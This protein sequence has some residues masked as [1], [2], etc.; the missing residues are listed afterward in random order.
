MTAALPALVLRRR[1]D[2]RLRTGHPW[3]FSNEVDTARTPLTQFRPGDWVNLST[4]GGRL[5]GTAYVNP[6]TLIAAR[7]VSRQ[8]DRPLDR[9]CIKERVERALSLRDRLYARP[10]Y[11]LVYAESDGLPG[12]VIDR[13]GEVLVAQTGTQGMERLRGDIAAAVNECLE[14]RSLVFRNDA[15]ARTIEGLAQYV[16]TV[17]GD[18]PGSIQIDENGA[19]FEIDP[20]GG[21]KSGW[22]Y[23]HRDNRARL[24]R[25]VRDAR[26]LD[27]FSY[28]GGF[29][30]QAALAGAAAVVCVDSSAAACEL[31]IRNAELNDLSDRIRVCRDDAFEVLKSFLAGGEHFDVVVLDPPAFA[32][33]RKDVK[34]AL[35]AYT[36]LNR[37]AMQVLNSGGIL[38]SA[39][40]SS[41][42]DAERFQEA[43]RTAAR[44][45]GRELQ[46]LERGHQA[47]D[48]PVHPALPE[49]DYLKFVIGRVVMNRDW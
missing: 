19:R 46:I 18:P 4:Q 5:L 34:A 35:E 25:Y 33:R 30:I 47:P 22:F 10:Y 15:P 40:C 42:V 27:V 6:N 3:V 20:L 23:D 12:L 1:Q 49:S 29:G 14:P 38:A 31:A 44:A 7:L 17:I 8:P 37:Y 41:H 26:V 43:L 28:A 39:S 21:Q 36:R 45:A 2:R 9:A 16:E 32:R 11:R 48:H 24:A 13:H